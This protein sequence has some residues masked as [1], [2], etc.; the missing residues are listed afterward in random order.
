MYFK[1]FKLHSWGKRSAD[2]RRR[3]IQRL[4]LGAGE[5]FS[6][7]RRADEGIGPY[8]HIRRLEVLPGPHPAL[9]P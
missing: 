9:S 2:N 4:L 8:G 3:L 1:F 7:Y 5:D 6:V